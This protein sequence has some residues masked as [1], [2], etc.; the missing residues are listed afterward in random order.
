MTERTFPSLLATVLINEIEP[1]AKKRNITLKSIRSLIPLFNE[2]VV[3][4]FH[5]MNTRRET[6][7][8]LDVIF[9][10]IDEGEVRI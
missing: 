10:G 1:R 6:R 5:K 9:K 2:L 7:A 8:A 3:L 4:E